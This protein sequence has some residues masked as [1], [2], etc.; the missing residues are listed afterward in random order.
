M[1]FAADCIPYWAIKEEKADRMNSVG[2]SLDSRTPQIVNRS[3]AA[4]C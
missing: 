1:V 2:G 3:F 4:V